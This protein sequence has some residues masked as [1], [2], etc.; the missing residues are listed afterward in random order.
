MNKPD[1]RTYAVGLAGA[2]TAIVVGA[3]NSYQPSHQIDVTYASSIQ[4]VI[5]TLVAHFW[6][7]AQ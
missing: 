1:D 7:T 4:V 5:S 2:I 6:P 3:W